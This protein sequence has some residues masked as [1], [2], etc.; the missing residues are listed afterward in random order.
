MDIIQQ[1]TDDAMELSSMNCCWP[2]GTMGLQNPEA[3]Q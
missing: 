2:P 3:D 1:G